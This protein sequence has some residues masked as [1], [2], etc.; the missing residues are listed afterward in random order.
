MSSITSMNVAHTFGIAR[1][2]RIALTAG[3]ALGEGED[4]EA[5]IIKGKGPCPL[6]TQGEAK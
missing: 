4:A 6:N 5:A 3:R 1:A 2:I